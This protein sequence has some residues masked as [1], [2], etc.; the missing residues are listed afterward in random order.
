MI[1]FSCSQPCATITKIFSLKFENNERQDVLLAA[2]DEKMLWIFGVEE[3]FILLFNRGLPHILTQGIHYCSLG[4][5]RALLLWF[6][7]ESKAST[8]ATH[9]SSSTQHMH[10]S[11][12]TH[13]H[14]LTCI[15]SRFL[16]QQQHVIVQPLILCAHGKVSPARLFTLHLLALLVRAAVYKAMVWSPS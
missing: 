6:N 8:H 9:A 10:L 3:K 1:T 16:Q 13:A 14:V 11:I 12:H 15:S 4:S 5:T 2:G 7:M